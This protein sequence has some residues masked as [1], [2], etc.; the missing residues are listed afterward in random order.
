MFLS[1]HQVTE[2]EILA[3][4]VGV[5]HQGHLIFEG[6]I[7]SLQEIRSGN[8]EVEL[9]VSAPEACV[10]ALEADYTPRIIESNHLRIS[11]PGRQYIPALLRQILDL[12]IDVFGVTEAKAGLEELFVSLTKSGTRK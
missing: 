6:S 2:I 5:L 9:I 1:S 7:E 11:L 12:K 4:E 3:T 8:L 10:A